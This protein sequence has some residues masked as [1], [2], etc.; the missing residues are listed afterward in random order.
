M[1]DNVLGDIQKVDVGIAFAHFDMTMEENGAS[2]RFVF[3]DPG[4][5]VPADVHYIIT[6]ERTK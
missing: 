1:K 3:E 5:T 4:I 2:G 6:Y